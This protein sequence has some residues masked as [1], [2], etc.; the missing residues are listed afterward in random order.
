MAGRPWKILMAV[1]KPKESSASQGFSTLA[2]RFSFRTTHAELRLVPVKMLSVLGSP[3]FLSH[4]F[5]EAISFFRVALPQ[6]V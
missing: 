3:S 2:I 1:L 4:Q 6:L 5:S